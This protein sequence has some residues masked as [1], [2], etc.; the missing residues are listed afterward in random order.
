MQNSI[1]LIL[2]LILIIPMHGQGAEIDYALHVQIDTGQLAA[3]RVVACQMPHSR[4]AMHL[5]TIFSLCDVDKATAF[6][7]ACEGGVSGCLV[8]DVRM[9]GMDG[10]D[11]LERIKAEDAE[12]KKNM[13]RKAS[14]SDIEINGEEVVVSTVEGRARAKGGDQT[15]V[16]MTFEID[17]GEEKK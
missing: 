8:L 11:L 15:P 10:V 14:V 3:E 6:L 17:E 1:G 2:L 7:D 12:R 5:D 9:P 13:G 4:A 16:I